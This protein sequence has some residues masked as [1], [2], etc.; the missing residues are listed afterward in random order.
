MTLKVISNSPV[1]LFEIDGFKLAFVECRHKIR[2]S[3]YRF[4]KSC[5]TAS[6]V[7][8]DMGITAG[9]PQI[10]QFVG[11]I[12]CNL[13]FVLSTAPVIDFNN[14]DTS[15]NAVFL[16]VGKHAY[17]W[18]SGMTGNCHGAV[19]FTDFQHRF[20]RQ[21]DAGKVECSGQSFSDS[22]DQ[23]MPVFGFDLCPFEDDQIEFFGKLRVI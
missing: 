13:V 23:N 6:Y 10:T 7:A 19:L 14:T 4:G 16:G 2:H 3:P 15:G 18:S 21:I 8:D 17:P 22:E 9:N 12:Q 11:V 20:Q 5:G 1:L